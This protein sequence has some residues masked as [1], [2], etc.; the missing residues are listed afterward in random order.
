MANFCGYIRG[1]RSDYDTWAEMVDDD[2]F[3]WKNVVQRYCELENLH[4]TPDDDPDGFVRLRDGVHGF[5][6]PV[7]LSLAARQEWPTGLDKVMKA[8]LQFGWPLNQDQNSGDLIGV[9]SISTTTYKGYRVTS[10]SAYLSNPPANLTI[11]THA[12]ATKLLFE[13]YGNSSK[14]KAIGVEL[15]DG[16]KPRAKNEVILALGTI[17][18]PKLLM[19]SGI[20]PKEDLRQLG[21]PSLVNLPRLGKDM[22]DHNYVI[23]SWGANT[24]LGTSVDRVRNA[25][26]VETARKQWRKDRSGQDA[27]LNLS[28]LLAFVK[29]DPKRSPKTFEELEKLDERTKKWIKHPQTPQIELFLQGTVPEEFDTKN[30]PECFMLGIMSMQPQSR[31]T[32]RLA[33]KDPLEMPLID[34]NY[35]DH[36]YDSR[37]MIEG[38]REGFN[39]IKSTDLS[40]YIVGPNLTPASDSDEDILKFLKTYLMPILHPVGTVR[41]GS[42]NDHS[43]CLDTDFRIRGVDGLRV[44]DLSVCPLITSN[45]TQATAYVVGQLGWKQLQKEYGLKMTPPQQ[46]L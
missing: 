25:E 39:L 2:A 38:V 27:W 23:V 7:D 10:A 42:S 14:P 28:N 41:M 40:K 46:K 12:L 13:K 26:L 36:P 30:G 1:S 21:I 34:P 22:I 37:M 9:G 4:F 19:L 8:S 45:H 43:A 20:G 33:S 5:E 17:D 15:A 29:Y 3:K 24:E 6:G 18:T 16:R 35:F 31:G 32:V 11:W 44:M